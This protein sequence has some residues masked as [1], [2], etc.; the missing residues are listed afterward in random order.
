MIVT[1]NGQA[2][3]DKLNELKKEGNVTSKE[4]CIITDI[5]MPLMDGHRLTKLVKTDEE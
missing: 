1:E 2:A 5:E 3:W 4:D